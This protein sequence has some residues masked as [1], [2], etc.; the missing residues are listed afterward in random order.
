ME[1]FCTK[2]S[3]LPYPG[4]CSGGSGFR[5]SEFK[6]CALRNAGVVGPGDENKTEI[7]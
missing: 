6:G 4:C 1:V 2:D 5:G 7:A 3:I